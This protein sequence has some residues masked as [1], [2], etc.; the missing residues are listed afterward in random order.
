VTADEEARKQEDVCVRRMRRIMHELRGAADFIETFCV[1]DEES[2]ASETPVE[3]R[4]T[5]CS[6]RLLRLRKQL[7]SMSKAM[8]VSRDL[9]VATHARNRSAE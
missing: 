2:F 1:P 3:Q 9:L 6:N 7:E 8:H 4:V 5:E